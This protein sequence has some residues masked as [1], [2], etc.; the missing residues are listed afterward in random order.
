MILVLIRQPPLA[1]AMMTRAT[2]T[3][4]SGMKSEVYIGRW[5]RFMSG[6]TKQDF[7]TADSCFEDQ[8]FYFLS[9]DFNPNLS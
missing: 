9:A 5:L 6:M 2:G 7:Q 1:V 3:V 4:V 8:C